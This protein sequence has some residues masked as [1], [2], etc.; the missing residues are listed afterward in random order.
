MFR[1]VLL[2]V[3]LFGGPV[4]IGSAQT[5][6]FIENMYDGTGGASGNTIAVHESNNR[7][8][9]DGLTYSGTGDMRTTNVSSGYSGASGTWNVMLNGVGETFIISGVNTSDHT[10]LVLSFGVKK[11]TTAETGTNLT[12]EVSSD[13]TSWSALTIAAFPTGTGT[14]IWYARTASGTIPST[15][16]LRI[17]FTG[18]TTQQWNIDDVKLVGT[19]STPSSCT[20][21]FS[22][23]YTV[24]PSL[25][26]SCTN[27]QSIAA[28]LSDIYNGTRPDGNSYRNGPGIDGPVIFEVATGTYA[29]RML[30][31]EVTGASSTNTVTF[32]SASGVNTDVVLSIASSTVIGDPNY[33]V[34]LDGADHIRFEDMTFERTGTNTYAKVID[35]KGNA[36]YNIFDGNRFLGRATG[37]SALSNHA[38]VICEDPNTGNTNNTFT[39]NAFLNGHVGLYWDGITG[40]R[41]SALTVSNN[42]FSNYRYGIYVDFTNNVT[43]SGNTITAPSSYNTASMEG[44]Y[45]NGV[46]EILTITGNNIVLNSASSNDGISIAACSSSSSYVGTIANNMI[47]VGGSGTVNGIN[48]G[49]STSYKNYYY[50]SVRC[51]GSNASSSSAFYM[52][53]SSNINIINNVLTATI[54]NAIEILS[55]SGVISSNYNDL[56]ST[57]AYVGYWTANRVDLAAWRTASGHDANSVSVD[58]GFVSG[59]DLHVGPGSSIDALATPLAITTDFD[60]QTRHATTPDIGADEY[61]NTVPSVQLSVNTATGTEAGTTSITLTATASATVSGAQTVDLVL[62]GTGLTAAD[63]SGIDF[64]TAQTITIAG[65][66][67]TGTVT[68]NVA[69][70]ATYE[71]TE[72]ATFTISNPSA[73]IIL[74]TTVAQNVAITDNDFPTAN[75]SINTGTGSEAAATSITLTATSSANVIGAQTVSVALSGTG[76]TNSDFSG[77]T[78]PA[79]I[80]IANGAST[81]S[82]TF[83][84]ANDVAVEWTE[85]ATFTISSPS[86]CLAL[87]AT[88]TQNLVITDNDL[89]SVSLGISPSSGTEAATTAV[90]LTVTS[91]PAVV[92]DQTV[93]VALSGTGMTNADFTGVTFPTTITILDG[94]TT[95]TLTFNIADDNVAEATETA[96]FTIGSPSSGIV[97]GSPITR[98]LSIT[99][100]PLTYIDLTALNVAATEDFSGMGTSS[101][102]P[103]PTG[104]GIQDGNTTTIATAVTVQSSNGSPTAGGSYNWG[105]NGTTDRGLGLMF[106]GSY[107]SKSIIAAVKNSTGSSGT[108]FEISFNYE[109][110]RRNSSTQTFKLQYSTSMTSGWVDVAGAGF[111]SISSGSSSYNFTTLVASQAIVDLQFTPAAPVA[112]GAI[113]YFRWILDG[114]S[115]SSG[116][117]IDDFSIALVTVTCADPTVEASAGNFTGVSQSAITLNWTAGN[118]DSRLVYVNSTGTITPPADGAT[119]PS[120]NTVWANSGQ[121]L[122]YNG[123]GTSATVTGLDASTTYYFEVYEYNCTAGNTKFLDA[124]ITY[125]Q[126]TTVP[127]ST[128]SIVEAISGSEATVIDP[129]INGTI[130]SNSNGVQVW[131]FRLHDGNGT[132]NDADALPTIYKGWTIR[133]SAGNTVPNWSTAIGARAFFLGSNT[134]PLAGGGLTN[135]SSIL[136]PV[137]SPFVTVPDNGYVD[138][139]MRITLADPL[140]AGSDGQHFGF[141]IVAADVTVETDVLLSSQL[142]SF[143]LESNSALNEIDIQA[144]LQFIS[145]PTTVGLGDQF[146]VTVSAIDANGNI[147]VDDNTLITLGQTTGSGTLSGSTSAN[148]INGTYTWTGL[149]YDVEETFEVTASGG[150]Y[151]DISAYINV[152]DADHQLFDDFNRT[153]SF[154]VGIPSSGGSTSYSE[155]GTGDGSRQRING[156]QL[157]LSNCNS[158]GSSSSNGFEQ[159]V[160]NMETKYETTFSYAGEAMNWKFNIRSSRP[161]PSGFPVGTYNTYAA[162]VVLGCDESDYSASTADGYAVIIGNQGDPDPVKLVRFSGGIGSLNSNV[163]VT[164]VAVASI[165]ETSFLSVNVSFDPCTDQW[166]LWVRD[167][168]TGFA[169]PNSGTFGSPVTATNTSLT[170]LNLKYS[171]FAFQHGS[172]CG[173]TVAFDNF[174]I[175]IAGNASTT[176]RVWNGSVNTDW[177]EPNNW[178]PCPGVPTVTNNVLIPS[179]TPNDPHIFTGAT[180][181]CRSLTIQ[182]G[183]G[184]ELFIDGTGTLNVAIP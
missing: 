85:T 144:T 145:A 70:D 110:F 79:T 45:C 47:V 155:S 153:N 101:S 75:L 69:N 108:V 55:T 67:T 44:I 76:L 7:F 157:I 130:V 104:F 81:G 61:N 23:T 136:F 92:G 122:I 181:N 39:G 6:I 131:R 166:S 163:N 16:N 34:Q 3:A 5:T 162:V 121:Q 156:N 50:N 173:E 175:P 161:D 140:P 29:E 24:N 100:N 105:Q 112:D 107:F 150:S 129:L 125:F 132:S 165:G 113:V 137:S 170:S 28:V 49:S 32:R 14:A 99:N 53:G 87:G 116:V 10:S 86:S 169:E 93:S 78:F 68:F 63:F 126:A 177:H 149:S 141:S 127:A 171:G 106:S 124:T 30:L 183:L 56:Y 42:T 135:P 97:L 40:T 72:T 43:I 109:Q 21:P 31:T 35:V 83:T 118:G 98:N 133:P 96:T 148:L 60:G 11:E 184:A 111:S 143:S 123:T 48:S 57:G 168:G 180:G 178:D 176:D 167:D 77:I 13:G 66:A 90:T 119:L 95:G 52:N 71:C 12:V 114:S 74:G 172:S 151:A 46:G 164:D 94:A 152:I 22:G 89:P 158:D 2:V 117:G 26:A 59:T 102:A 19:L 146:T 73:G 20:A 179:G 142:G 134:T 25:A 8:Y 17:R 64:T 15:S 84:I 103:T 54:G 154:T 91:N 138:I 80:T 115:S 51:T 88:S 139:Y 41:P 120:V 4:S 37:A 65:G 182:S 82:V 128:A 174:H 38:L 18:L 33:V 159:V 58:P 36:S 147:D 1:R 9:E 160:F 62:S 27:Y